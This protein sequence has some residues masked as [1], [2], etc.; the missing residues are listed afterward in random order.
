[1]E[2]LTPPEPLNSTHI[3]ENFDSGSGPID[4]W[5][6]QRAIAAIDARTAKVF[7]VCRGKFVVAYFALAASRVRREELP[8]DSQQGLS[9]HP[10]PTILLARMGVDQ[11][12]QGQGIGKALVANA[13]SR[14][15]AATENIAAF[16]IIANAK[17]E[18]RSFYKQLGFLESP[19]DPS[20]VILPLVSE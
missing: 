4:A 8:N 17:E 16:A 20:L 2:G 15:L 10:V 1:M 9:N 5:L 12:F 13:V 14:A 6:K 18:S 7:V 11:N 3:L 19:K